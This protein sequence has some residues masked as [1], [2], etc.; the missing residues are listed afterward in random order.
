MSFKP[1][2]PLNLYNIDL[3]NKKKEDD[4]RLIEKMFELHTKYDNKKH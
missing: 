4:L 1:P 2:S 3:S